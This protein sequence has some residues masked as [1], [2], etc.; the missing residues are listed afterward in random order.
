[1]KRITF[2]ISA[3]AFLLMLSACEKKA[4]EGGNASIKGKVF[5]KDYNKT[6][7]SLNG[8]YYGADLEVYIIY[9]DEI[10]FGERLRTNHEGAFEFKYLRPGDYKIYVYSLDSTLKSPSEY[11]PVVKDVKISGKRQKVELPDIVVFL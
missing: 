7:T 9:G 4:G 6:F 1:M 10:N 11:I 8:Q 3:F 5:V 2:L